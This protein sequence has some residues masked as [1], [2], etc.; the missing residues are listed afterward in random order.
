M[1]ICHINI[2]LQLLLLCS[3]QVFAQDVIITTDSEVQ[4]TKVEEMDDSG[5][6]FH[7]FLPDS[8]SLFY[9]QSSKIKNI[10]FKNE[11]PVED[12]PDFLI[13]KKIDGWYSDLGSA[14][15]SS[16][17]TRVK[18]NIESYYSHL[19]AEREE[20]IRGQ[21][22]D[23]IIMANERQTDSLLWYI[24]EYMLATPIDKPGRAPLY[25]LLAQLYETSA[26]LEALERVKAELARH[27][28]ATGNKYSAINSKIVLSIAHVKKALKMGDELVGFWVSDLCN[29]ED[30]S[31]LYF[32][33]IQK[34]QGDSLEVHLCTTE[35]VGSFKKANKPISA[36]RTSLNGIKQQYGFS[37]ATDKIYRGNQ[38]LANGVVVFGSSLASTA[39]KR[40]T[41]SSGETNYQ[42]VNTGSFIGDLTVLAA[43]EIA[44]NRKKIE[45]IEIYGE[46]LT[47]DILSSHLLFV[48]NTQKV[49]EA[50]VD[51]V[52]EK[53]LEFTFY[54]VYPNY[55]IY[56]FDED[57]V[58]RGAETEYWTKDQQSEWWKTF[59]DSQDV[60]LKKQEQVVK[61][62]NKRSYYMLG[63]IYGRQIN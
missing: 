58:L 49:G 27:E 25:E 1:K 60:G 40:T 16:K 29:Q 44:K 61:D 30:S 14:K 10:W 15:T 56:F 35:D 45:T 2:V 31:P 17:K 59:S 26:N 47:Q 39:A 8:D 20:R 6:F 63:K 32:L 50:D 51:S 43:M 5:V 33:Y 19:D 42:P 3:E 38:F 21:L 41:M 34:N 23:R 53:D 28:Q 4:Q 36:L 11:W 7:M 52:L 55:N 24:E 37:F 22:L 62:C 12:T 9:L 54:R 13:I 48:T 18:S 46:R 57:G